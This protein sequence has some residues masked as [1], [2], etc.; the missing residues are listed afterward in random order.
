MARSL[1]TR[2]LKIACVGEAMAELSLIAP[3]PEVG[4]AGDALNT[5]VYL[6]R[7]LT[8]THANT[9]EVAFVS[10]VGVDPLSDRM[11]AFI[12]AQGVATR[13]I[14]THPDRLP[15]I[16]AIGTDATGERSFHYWRGDSAARTMFRD[17][18]GVL[19][20]FDVIYLSAI[21][22]AI[23]PADV[24][25]GLL[26]WLEGWPGTVAFDSNYRAR[27]WQSDA[28]AR[29]AVSRAWGRA[30]IGLPSLD[31]E[32]ALFGDRDEAEVL[33][34]LR[35]HGDGPRTGALKRGARGPASLSGAGAGGGDARCPVADS[36]VDTTAAGDSFNGG[37]LAA[38]LTGASEQDAMI[39]GHRLAVDVI[40]RPG[41]IVAGVP[42]G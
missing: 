13:C 39:A 4:F 6:H 10:A 18:F 27:L 11:T 36:V 30:D 38:L 12:A 24:R 28:A 41:A 42:A 14:A 15:G 5:A 23:L 40:A 20:G 35:G 8:K 29:Q 9:H 1:T 16:Y 37:F 34:R 19:D 22:L 21:T 32:M 2:P 26:E 33:A 31:D 25:L 17:G 7:S 3:R